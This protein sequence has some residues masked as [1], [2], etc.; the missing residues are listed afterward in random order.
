MTEILKFDNFEENDQDVEQK[1][2]IKLGCLMLYFNFTNWSEFIRNLISEE[3]IY[4]SNDD[5]DINNY[6]YENEPH[7]TILYG[8]H[9]YNNIVNDIKIYLP[10]LED[11]DD[12]LRCDITSFEQEEY[13]VIKFDIK[14]EKLTNLNN[15]LCE[16]FNYSNDYVYH[17]HITIAY[18]KKGTASKYIKTNLKQI[19]LFGDKYIYSDDEYNKT[20]III[21]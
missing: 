4:I 10:K 18:V 20:E 21:E 5:E 3:D 19:P 7:C 17:P 14:S 11:L 6:G 8:F 2:E 16:N 12:I 9:H 1:E 15:K 13:D